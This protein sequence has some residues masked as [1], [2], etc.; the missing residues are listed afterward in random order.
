[1]AVFTPGMRIECRN[2]EWLVHRVE[3]ANSTQTDQIIY[4]VGTDD[5]TRGHEAAFL[6]QLEKITP[7]DP[8]KTKLV[9]D[10]SGS[11]N[12]SK[13]FLEA[14]LR[15]MPLTDPDPHVEGIGAFKPMNYQK[16]V[17]QRAIS[18][19]R[20]RLLLADAV[21]LGKTIEV[22]M[23]LSELIKRGQ[24]KRILVLAKK[25]M[26]K[27]FQSELWNRFAIPLTRLDSEGLAK[28]QLKIPASKN[29][30]EVFSRIIMS[31]DTLKDIGRYSHFLED[32][33]WDAVVIDEAH[34]VSGGS[35]PEKHLSYRL[36]RRLSRRTNS[37]IL[38]TATPHN[39]KRETFGR[40]ISLLDPSAIPDP[41]LK[42]YDASD[43]KPFFMMRFKE[44]VRAEAG[45]NFSER[46][47]IPL[48]ETT[49]DA[50]DQEEKVYQR[51]AEIRNKVL[52][53]TIVSN[54]IV[55]WGMYKSFLSSPEAC[56]STA[57]KRLKELSSKPEKSLE[58]AQ[59]KSLVDEL[60]GLSIEQSSRFKLLVQQLE[61]M[62]WNG[63]PS[64]PR[65][66]IFTESRLTQD[67]L[68]EALAKH[69]KIKYSTKAEDQE[70]Q[71]LCITHGGMADTQLAE[72]VE[73]FGTGS[74]KIRMMVATDVASEGV[75]LHH[76]CHNIIHYDLPWSIITLIQRNGRIDRFGQE[77]NPI[78]RYL[79]V[80]SEQG[81]LKGDGELFERLVGKVDE[82]NR[83]T[84]TGESGMKLYDKDK[85]VEYFA[86]QGI[87]AGDT[88]ILDKANPESEESKGLEETL[89][90]ATADGHDD[91]MSFLT[92]QSDAATTSEVGGNYT[93]KKTDNSRARLMDDEEYLKRGY[94]T[95]SDA[96]EETHG[97]SNYLPL[98]QT[99]DQIIINPPE[100]LM[101]RLGSPKASSDVV[102]GATAIP[103]EAWPDDNQLY[104]TTKPDR[105]NDAI[106]AALAQKGQWSK[107]L[108]ITEQHPVMQWLN[109]RL[110]MLMARGEAPMITSPYLESGELLF[111][112]IGQ[113]SSRAGT[114]LIVDT[115]AVSFRKGGNIDIRPLKEAL[116]EVG[117]EN[118]ANTDKQGTLPDALLS[119]FVSSAVDQSTKHL[120]TLKDQRRALIKPRLEQEELRLKNWFQR[121]GSR[122]EEQLHG[123]P[124]EGKRA[125]KLRQQRE[126]MEKY[127]Q[128]REENWRNAH[129][130]AVDEPST[131]LVL[132]VEGV[133]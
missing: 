11:Y 116:A 130:L 114:P 107:E 108:L 19:L 1:M 105:V 3:S 68:S 101:R 29:P 96:I 90:A 95:L 127:L 61:K 16:E 67:A 83:S 36:A 80:E 111:C 17:V 52:D 115:H 46:V 76:Q 132:V 28:L 82:I 27:Q 35:N 33:R 59:L 34:N 66:L 53:K 93:E 54:A 120:K 15:Q 39:G 123:L 124:P 79:M 70:K 45:D 77:H 47:I 13:L 133:K 119:G 58:I 49:I 43:I 131:R 56:R 85:E 60:H 23:I 121:W 86:Q 128:D 55:Q 18:Q 26:L 126:E 87:L 40:L 129:F 97:K 25:S 37:M 65:V 69:F 98:Q 42:E 103:E 81:L 7:V 109:E 31:I 106:K 75:N 32:T 30:F 57:E 94:K 24:G 38:T 12:K 125:T 112:F 78:I 50:I 118:L 84:R 104:L 6:S 2:S 8:R 102:F 63:K 91:F 99:P 92:G 100:D 5:L 4:C 51:L 21:G 62:D 113:V 117:F 122:I 14:Q 64:S 71:V 9:R 73:A 48:T 89:L 44:D 74:S 20:P 41:Q 88:Q 72:I 10:E 22:G 110:M